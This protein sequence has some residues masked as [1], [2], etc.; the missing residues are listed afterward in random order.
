MPFWLTILIETKF[1][2][3]G[4]STSI[5]FSA[6]VPGVI[7]RPWRIMLKFLPIFLFFHSPIFHLFFLLFNPFFFS[8]YLFFSNMLAKK[9][10]FFF[11]YVTIYVHLTNKKI[12]A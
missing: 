12:I 5:D 4:N 3:V 1:V 11:F 6:E 10:N 9:H 8:M 2:P 7:A